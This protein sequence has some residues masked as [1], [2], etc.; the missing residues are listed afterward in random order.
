MS[1]NNGANWDT[2]DA[3]LR[4]SKGAQARQSIISAVKSFSELALSSPAYQPSA[5]RNGSIQ[6]ILAQ[7]TDNICK[8]QLSPQDT[9]LIGDIVECYNEH[10]IVVEMYADEYGLSTGVMWLCNHKLRFQNHNSE[11]HECY[12][13]I[14]DGSYSKGT[15]KS[16]TTADAQYTMYVPLNDDTNRFYIDKR[17]GIDVMYNQYNEQ[18]L[19][20][21]KITWIDKKSQN[22]GEGS[23]L[24]KLRITADLYNSE[25]DN[26]DEMICDYIPE[27]KVQE[28]TQESL[29]SLSYNLNG[30]DSI[31]I[32]SSRT[33]TVSV[34]DAEGNIVEGDYT[35]TWEKNSNTQATISQDGN[36]LKV[37]VPLNENLVGDV[38]EITISG[39]DIASYTKYVE[40]VSIG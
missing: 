29:N 22:Y 33:Y 16:I 19:Q 25:R 21:M 7:R 31:R 39:G 37:K 30:K 2:Y 17:F 36:E 35:F 11:I 6:P 32:G 24:L 3:Y 38:I 34:V 4:G 13:V 26:I 15:E 18:I 27:Q 10:W 40:V 23:H 1:N 20:V 28:D 12:C 9:M 14:D 5:K 8:I